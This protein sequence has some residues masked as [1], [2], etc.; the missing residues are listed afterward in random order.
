M[1]SPASLFAAAAAT[2][3]CCLF[4]HSRFLCI[5]RALQ[6]CMHCAQHPICSTIITALF[7]L[8]RPGNAVLCTHFVTLGACLPLELLLVGGLFSVIDRSAHATGGLTPHMQGVHTGPGALLDLAPRRLTAQSMSRRFAAI[9][10]T[11]LTSVAHN[12]DS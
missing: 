2:Q 12:W 7:L 1:K 10:T 4:L 9:C 11:I 6:H 8:G 3:H 5:L